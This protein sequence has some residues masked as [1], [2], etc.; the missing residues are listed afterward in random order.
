MGREAMRRYRITMA[1]VAVLLILGNLLI[2][3]STPTRTSTPA[4]GAS[5]TSATAAAAAAISLPLDKVRIGHHLSM[6]SLDPAKYQNLAARQATVLTSGQLFRFDEKR[7]IVPDLVQTWDVSSDGLIY[8]MKLREGLKFSD[9]SPLT[10]QDVVFSW[11]RVKGEVSVDKTLIKMVE[12]VESPDAWTLV[13]KLRTPNPDFLRWFGEYAAVIHPKRLADG[14]PKYFDHPVSAGPYMIKEWVPGGP[15]LLLEAN[16]YY[17]GGQMSIRQ[18]EVLYVPDT[19]SRVLQL[20]Q[21]SLDY[22]LDLP[23]PARDNLPPA[24]ATYPRSSATTNF[25]VFNIA[26]TGSPL[27]NRDVRHAISLAVDRQDVANKAF[28]GVASP[29]TGYLY[30]GLPE[31][32]D[33][34]PNGGKRDLEAARKLLASTPYAKGFDMNLVTRS[35]QPGWKEAALIIKE[36]LTDLNINVTLEVVEDAVAM[37]SLTSGNFEAQ[38]TIIGGY[39]PILLY[40]ASFGKGNLYPT[41]TGYGR[42][43]MDELLAKASS[44]MDNQK[45]LELF[46][47]VEKLAYEDVVLVPVVSNNQLLASRVPGMLIDYTTPGYYLYV[48]TLAK[49]KSGQ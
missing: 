35:S 41:A 29:Q 48:K 23:S 19:T 11:E 34:L 5:E 18:I 13:W 14:D 33:I 8:T 21:G 12:T 28:F 47:Q 20:A 3:C 4:T 46:H 36:N 45:R 7:N 6:T 32:Y 10:T 43:D 15:R 44:E 16:P 49:A 37:K 22:V 9:S 26:R 42:S 17:A 25:L 39:P 40:G 31:T 1:L 30:A 38:F 27:A 24:V 2:G